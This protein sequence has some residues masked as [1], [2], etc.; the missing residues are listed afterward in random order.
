MAVL[1]ECG[2]YTEM[3]RNVKEHSLQQFNKQTHKLI[4]YYL[5]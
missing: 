4:R 1:R 2:K 3:N 5:G